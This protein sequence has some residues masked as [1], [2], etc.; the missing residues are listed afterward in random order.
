MSLGRI[1]FFAPGVAPGGAAAVRWA[2]AAAAAAAATAAAIT[3]TLAAL[4]V[5]RLG[6]PVGGCPCE[7][8]P[9]HPARVPAAP[10]GKEACRVGNSLSGKFNGYADAK[11][12]Q[13]RHMGGSW[14]LPEQMDIARHSRLTAHAVS[15]FLFCSARQ[16][17]VTEVQKNGWMCVPRNTFQTV[18]AY[19]SQERC[20]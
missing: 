12:R 18:Q 16:E 20:A 17:T 13:W 6:A 5:N 2:T 11:L 1:T 19:V 8:T 10:Q 7:P 3:T 4:Q 9:L 15:A 14:T